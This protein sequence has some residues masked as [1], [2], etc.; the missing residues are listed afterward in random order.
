MARATMAGWVRI[1]ALALG[2]AAS[3]AAQPIEFRFAPPANP[4]VAN[5]FARELWAEA[6][7]PSGRRIELPAYYAGDGVYAIHARADEAG[8]YRLGAVTEM[9]TG[10]A[11]VRLDVHLTSPGEVVNATPDRVPAIARDPRD[12][13]VF[14]G[15][16]GRPYLPVGANLAWPQGPRGLDYLLDALP[17][18]SRADLN[19]MRVWM[20]HWSGMNLDWF[21]PYMGPSPSPG[22]LDEGVARK[23]D[24]LVAAADRNGVYL[25]IVLQHHGQYTTHSNPNWAENPWNAANPGGF[26]KAP[27]DFFTDPRARALT[28]LK[29]RAIVARWSWSPTIFAWELFNEV[30]WTNAMVDGRVTDVARWHDEMADYIRSVDAYGHLVTTSTENLRS[31]IYR[32]LDFFQP[33][34]YPVD[35]IAAVRSFD[36]PVAELDRP[37]FYGEFGDDSMDRSDAVRNSGLAV[38]PGVWASLMGEGTMAAQPWNGWQWY[39][40]H[41]LTELGAVNRFLTRSG[42]AG[43]AG[44]RPFSAVVACAQRVPLRILASTSW[45]RHAEPDIAYPL[46]GRLPMAAGSIPA[47]L[48]GGRGVNAN[49]FPGW[50]TYRLDLPRA[51]TVRIQIGAVESVGSALRATVDGQRAAAHRWAGGPGAPVP[52]ELSFPVAAGRHVLR[53]ENDGGG[54][55][56]EVP[57]VDLGFDTSALAAIGRRNDRCIAVWLWQRGNVDSLNPTGPVGGVLELADVPAGRW[58]ATWWDTARGEPGSS[59]AIDH[60]GGKLRLPTPPILRHAAV[61][62][63]RAS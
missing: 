30:H 37:V 14:R 21:P 52:A 38:L 16:D 31:P 58:V 49:G 4:A 28:R 15:S 10:A 41:R 13:H 45:Q 50:V 7:T 22:T 48:V 60:G 27:A 12:V 23:W 20:A 47:Y 17:E 29:Y 57:A 33:H 59:A 11:P 19:W 6:I 26:L 53:I 42:L 46:D 61:V 5:A 35:P 25:Q 44:L 9:A 2:L 55:W 63:A 40:Q 34:A 56:I 39:E 62:L 43:Q 18:F 54:G 24:R 3:A 1:G 51:T 36:R 8:R 32:R